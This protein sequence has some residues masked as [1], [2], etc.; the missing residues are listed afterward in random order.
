MEIDVM[1]RHSESPWRCRF[2]LN[3]YFV[4]RL[5]VLV[6]L[7]V[8]PT[9]CVFAQEAADV[10]THVVGEKATDD[11]VTVQRTKGMQPVPVPE[12]SEKALR[13][14]HSG[15]LLWIVNTLWGLFI[16]ALILFTGFSARIRD[17]ARK[18]GRK[19]ILMV[20]VYVLIY[21]SLGFLL[22]LPLNYYAEFVRQH[23]YEL[24]NQSFSQWLEDSLKWFM[25]TLVI[26]VL[27]L[28]IA[29][30]LLKKSPQRWWFYTTLA[31]LPLLFLFTFV[32]PIW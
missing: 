4:V 27:A 25:V 15:N 2:F 6:I 16:P 24:S 19:W 22:D 5:S 31:S 7:S 20:A 3:N 1:N 11:P 28:W 9:L 14:Y 17:L 32:Q 21:M 18:I 10:A 13:Y 30:Y 26:A 23:E 12:V 8:I 29:Y